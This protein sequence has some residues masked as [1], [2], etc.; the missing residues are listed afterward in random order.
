VEIERLVFLEAAQINRDLSDSQI[1]T[2]V[3]YHQKC[4]QIFSNFKFL[5][6][7]TEKSNNNLM[8]LF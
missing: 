6:D 4:F 2:E 1:S 7:K 5:L 3:L 8:R